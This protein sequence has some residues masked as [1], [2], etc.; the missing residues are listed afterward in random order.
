MSQI[1]I[2]PVT[3]ETLHEFAQFLHHH[4]SNGRSPERWA[5][6]LG[7]SWNEERPNYGFVLKDTGEIVGGIGAFYKTRTVH[8]KVE[9]F[10]NITSWCV[11]D[12]Y[13]QHSMRLA[14]S[15]IN[16]PGYHFSDFTP[17]QVVS[18]TLRF[19]KFEPLDERIAVILNLPWHPFDRHKVLYRTEDIEQ[20]LTG[21]ALQIYKDH[22]TFPWLEH[23]LVGEKD[24]YCHIIYK[25]TQFKGLP[26]VMIYY[27]SDAEL[28]E[29]YFK[30][31]AS[32]F[33]KNGYISTHIELRFLKQVPWPAKISS[34]FNAKLY[35]S[36]TLSPQD[37]DYL[38]SELVALDL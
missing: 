10:C 33:I 25:K 27:L 3:S 28:F 30:F 11:L 34:G 7:T 20:M 21:E 36:K 13:R 22:V 31:V 35:L 14:L 6:E 24:R 37:I 26:A 1:T 12:K 9:K 23:L 32:Y 38:Y 16:Q 5:S 29:K 4:L 15:I 17:T 19:F 18:A 2:E 8:G